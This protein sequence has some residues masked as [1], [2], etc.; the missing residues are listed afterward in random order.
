[1][2][3]IDLLVFRYE[4][5]YVVLVREIALVRVRDSDR[6]LRDGPDAVPGSSQQLPLF[7]QLLF[8]AMVSDLL[9]TFIHTYI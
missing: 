7:I 8:D 1:M 6:T 4:A 3:R 2:L 9:H 5:I